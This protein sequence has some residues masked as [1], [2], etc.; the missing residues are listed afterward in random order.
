MKFQSAVSLALLQMGA[1]AVA[2][3][4]VSRGSDQEYATSLVRASMRPYIDF[5]SVTTRGHR[6]CK[7]IFANGREA[8]AGGPPINFPEKGVVLSTGHPRFMPE[9]NS[10]GQS[11]C[12]NLTGDPY[13]SNQVGVATSDAC[14]ISFEFTPPSNADNVKIGYIFGSDEYI[15]WVPREYNDGFAIVVNGENIA[16]VPGTNEIVSVHSIN[17]MNN[18]E[19]FVQN[20]P[21]QSNAIPYPGFEPDGFTTYLTAKQPI[22]PGEVNTMSFRIADASDCH[23]DSWVMLSNLHLTFDSGAYGDPHFKTWSGER[24][25]FHGLCDL[26]L[27]KNEEFGNGL[28]MDVHIRTSKMKF[29]SYVSSAAIKIGKDV[30]EISGGTDGKILVNGVE[31]SIE[32]GHMDVLSEL[33]G[34]PIYVTGQGK[35]KREFEIHLG[36]DEKI[37]VSTWHSFVRVDFEEATEDN[38]GS[39]TGLMGSFQTGERLGRDGSNKVADL[40]EFGSEWQV[41]DSEPKLFHNTEGPQFPTKCEIPT[42]A[43]MRRRLGESKVTLEE[44]KNACVGANKDEVELCIFDV[45]ATGNKST[46]GAY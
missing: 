18:S 29:W 21:D 32:D 3:L 9:N 6:N 14:I 45:L 16:T 34:F 2:G 28:G 23:Y 1:T 33:S 24:Y 46:S 5:D 39:S 43:E 35:G 41:G 10:G 17:Y 7:A 15:E 30:F 38:F 12:F 20:D 13:I 40:N 27:L 8:V 36:G 44:A 31:K 19:F 25:D 37:K 22:N 11:R 42:S 4:D 26:V